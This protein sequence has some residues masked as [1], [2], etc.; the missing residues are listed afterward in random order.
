M[1]P[2]GA[3]VILLVLLAGIAITAHLST[4]DIEFS[5]Y[6]AGWTGTSGF[7]SDLERR[8]AQD[9]GSY[10][11]LFGR[12]DTML[13][14][15]APNGSFS[16]G[17]IARVREFLRG[18]NNTVFVADETGDPESE[19]RGVDPA[20][21]VPSLL[22]VG[23]WA[24]A[25]VLASIGALW[26]VRKRSP[27]VLP[28]QVPARFRPV[29][30]RSEPARPGEISGRAPLSEDT[31]IRYQELCATV[32]I[33]GR[34]P[35]PEDTLIRYQ[36]LCAAGDWSGAAQILYRSVIDRFLLADTER[37]TPS[38][39]AARIAGTPAG[40]AFGSFVTRY[41]EV[42]YGGMPLQLQDMLV[43]FW[44]AVLAA[45]EAGEGA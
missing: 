32:G 41:E 17:E 26:Y 5:R 7:F 37:L 2:A 29:L 27:Q 35:V 16:P 9:L 31:L 20:P 43:S 25:L 21:P 4:T 38:E 22:A 8:G 13:L 12:S 18:G 28:E 45:F 15:I 23:V 34:A 42:R 19:L 30:P 11:D 6:N 40:E 33:S 14:L 1:K 3:V 10:D 44:N 36:E 24:G 39:V